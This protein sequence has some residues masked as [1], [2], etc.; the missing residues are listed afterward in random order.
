MRFD[1]FDHGLGVRSLLERLA[2]FFIMEQLGNIGQGVKVL[3]ELPLG[4]QKK[5][6][7]IDRLII[8]RVKINPL[9]ERPKRPDHFLDQIGGGM[10]DADAKADAR[11]SWR[12]RVFLRPSAMASR[13]SGLILPVETRLLMSSSI[14]SQRLVA[15]SSAECFPVLKCRQGS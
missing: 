13:F 14:A 4:D 6:D 8:Q 15:F 9:R 11:C 1:D 3:L 10:R 12:T 2:E 5:H 7:Q